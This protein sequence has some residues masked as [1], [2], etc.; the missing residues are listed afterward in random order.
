[1]MKKLL[2]IAVILPALAVSS[3]AWADNDNDERGNKVGQASMV[4]SDA[5]TKHECSAC[6]MPYPP[7]LLPARSWKK[8]MTNLS[9]HFGEDASLDKKTRIH[10]ERYMMAMA[11]RNG[12]ND[13]LRISKQRWFV[14]THRG[15]E[16]RYVGPGKRVQTI[17]N[18]KACHSGAEKGWYGE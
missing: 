16:A 8:I 13:S 15:V 2:A 17:S 14:G 1:M 7:A 4:V 9:N 12:G 10:I 11:P 3:L 5:I 18:C 6:H